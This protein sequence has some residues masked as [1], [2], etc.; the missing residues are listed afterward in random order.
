M[1]KEVARRGLQDRLSPEQR[2]FFDEAMRRGLIQAQE[3]A[4]E[5][6]PFRMQ[7]GFGSYTAQRLSQQ[8]TE[9]ELADRK[10]RL[11]EL[12]KTD[13]GMAM[14][15]EETGPVEAAVVGAGRG[16]ANLGRFVGLAD[17][18]DER[19]KKTFEEL[20]AQQPTLAAG[21]IVGEAAPFAAVG[22]PLTSLAKS[23]AGRVGIGSAVGGTESAASVIGR[24][25]T[26]EEAVIPTAIG[27]LTGGVGGKL[28]NYSR[29]TAKQI[30][31]MR[32]MAENPRN[33]DFAKYLVVN[34][35]PE[36]S[37]KLA[38][39]AS[40]FGG[41]EGNAV[42]AVM[43]NANEAD[44]KAFRSMI[45]TIK[46]GK[47]DPLFKDAN[48]VGD[49]VGD[50]LARRVV[51]LRGLNRDAGK[52]IDNVARTQLKGKR[53]DLS[54]AK[55]NFSKKL[56]DLRVQYDPATGAVD[57]A[58]SALE[59]AGGA[60]ARDIVE[61][62]AR[63]MAKGDID[64]ADAHFTKRLIDQKVSFGSSEG[65]LAGEIDRAIKGLR[66]DINDS[67][68][69]VS[70]GYAKANTKYSDT[71]KALDNLQDAAGSKLDLESGVALRGAIRR[72]TSNAQARDAMRNSLDEIENVTRKYGVKFKDDIRTQNNIANALER[73]FKDAAGETSL[74]SEVG[75][76]I[77]D[78]ATQSNIGRAVSVG[79]TIAK[80]LSA[81][82]NQALE[83]LLG[84][85]Q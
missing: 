64:A 56:A 83:S 30:S 65:G 48:R 82:D 31:M 72:L 54:Q 7:P 70:K 16:F 33:P 84:A 17:Q 60:Q 21:E 5:S 12:R 58:D 34:G 25:G 35:K 67:I 47:V 52:R 69:D 81:D 42:V 38:K 75:K 85:I 62:A 68:R 78:A 77:T 79:K 24:G 41:D 53:V 10:A 36:V 29:P 61:R 71:I 28:Y 13:P 76:S 14:Q 80:K 1:F 6:E 40:D 3:P 66:S 19:T 44:R 45:N 57:F 8:S 55:S 50:S 39:A 73:R 74:R 23:T 37:K 18:E 20:Q 22:G 15:I 49:V 59:G 11:D 43:K 32:E 2:A 46:G 26:A 51:A 27:V 63:I 4:Q 9:K